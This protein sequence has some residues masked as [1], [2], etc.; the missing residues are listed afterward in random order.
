MTRA[1]ASVAGVAQEL[2]AVVILL[3]ERVE[4]ARR[5]HRRGLGR[6]A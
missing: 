4:R 5:E 1:S 2:V 6:A 3:L